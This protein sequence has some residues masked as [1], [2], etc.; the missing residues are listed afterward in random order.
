MSC[1]GGGCCGYNNCTKKNEC[2]PSNGCGTATYKHASYPLTAQQGGAGG[3]GTNNIIALTSPT[4]GASTTTGGTGGAPGG[5]GNPGGSLGGYVGGTGGQSGFAIQS[6][7]TGV[8][9]FTNTGTAT[10]RIQL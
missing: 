1:G 2:G 5:N 4:T 8:I 10:G 9:N 7:I 3:R 6:T